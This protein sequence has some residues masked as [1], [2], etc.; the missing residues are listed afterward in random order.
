MAYAGSIIEMRDG[1]REFGEVINALPTD[2]RAIEDVRQTA[3]AWGVMFSTSDSAELSTEGFFLAQRLVEED[4]HLITGLADELLDVGTMDEE[5]V[6]SW[7]QEH[8]AG[9]VPFAI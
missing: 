5:A 8:T 1:K 4:E 6:L 3:V 7:Y 2:V 9:E